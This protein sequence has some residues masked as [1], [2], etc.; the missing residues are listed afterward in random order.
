MPPASSTDRSRVV[1]CGG[2]HV[3]CH[4]WCYVW[5]ALC[6]VSRV[7]GVTCGPRLTC[8]CGGCHVWYSGHV[9][10]K[11]MPVYVCRWLPY[12]YL[13]VRFS[14]MAGV[15]S[16]AR[17][18]LAPPR[19]TYPGARTFATYPGVRATYP[20]VRTFASLAFQVSM[21]ASNPNPN[22]NLSHN[23]NL[24]PDHEWILVRF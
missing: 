11:S 3:W 24:N 19:P 10:K 4:V 14:N 2:C 20:G 21:C 1:T 8:T 22:H 17:S 15:V 5:W 18:G 12:E 9:K 16:A 23:P 13:Q 6:L 7:V